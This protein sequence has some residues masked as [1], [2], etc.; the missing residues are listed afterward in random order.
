MKELLK[1]IPKRILDLVIKLISVKGLV[2]GVATILK[3]NNLL[4]SWIWLLCAVA[5]LSFRT[6]EKILVKE[7]DMPDKP[8]TRGLTG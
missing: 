5:I 6:F 1:S 8:D 2:F 4:D 3:F 7:I